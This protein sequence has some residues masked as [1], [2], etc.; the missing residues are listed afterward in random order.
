MRMCDVAILKIFNASTV[1][2]R[3]ATVTMR[4]A[5]TLQLL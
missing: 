2:M 4:D 5:I 3:V 1:T